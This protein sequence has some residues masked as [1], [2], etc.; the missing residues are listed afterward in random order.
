[1]KLFL[2][3][4]VYISIN[5]II[6]LCASSSSK[7]N[8]NC[9]ESMQYQTIEFDTYTV[10]D[11]PIARLPARPHAVLHCLLDYQAPPACSAAD[12]TDD[13]GRSANWNGSLSRFIGSVDRHDKPLRTLSSN[14]AMKQGP[15]E[16]HW[17][18]DRRKE[19]LTGV[20]WAMYG[21]MLAGGSKY[22][23]LHLVT[24]LCIQYIKIVSSYTE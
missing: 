12:G 11:G 3:P 13:G 22:Y 19:L 10:N 20:N 8:A 23:S 18:I 1:M 17:P 6:T 21:T 15:L 7:F 24:I 4:N 9:I 14:T 2:T 16:G 5:H